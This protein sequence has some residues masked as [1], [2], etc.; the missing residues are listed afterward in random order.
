MK[1]TTVIII[2]AALFMGEN[3]LT[4][5][6]LRGIK[7]VKIKGNCWII[8]QMKLDGNGYLTF[9]FIR[10]NTANNYMWKYPNQYCG[11]NKIYNV[12]TSPPKQIRGAK[13]VKGRTPESTFYIQT[14][15]KIKTIYIKM[16]YNGEVVNRSYNVSSEKNK[17]FRLLNAEASSP[18]WQVPFKA[19]ESKLEAEAKADKSPPRISVFTPNLTNR[20]KTLKVDTYKTNIRGKVTDNKGVMTV[21]VNGRKAGVKAD[22]T[23]AARVK[24]AIGVNKIKVQAEDVN[25]NISERKFTIIREEFIPEQT[26]ADVDMPP[27]TKMKNPDGLAVVIGI[28][29][30]QYV[31]DATFAYND[32]EVFREY[33]ADTI[34]Y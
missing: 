14:T 5:Q 31:S 18:S 26:L 7:T 30:Y 2:L 29:N 12:T 6:G 9:R 20:A 24:L 1:K 25:G 17:L 11:P 15:S 13:G 21:M 28:E 19:S 27:K 16:L 34:G 8:N 10:D 33:L 3:T 22:G 23:F 4:A 32:A